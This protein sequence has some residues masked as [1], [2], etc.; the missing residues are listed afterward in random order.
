MRVST[1]AIRLAKFELNILADIL[2][3][4]YSS[5]GGSYAIKAALD[6]ISVWLI[7]VP[8]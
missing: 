4:P 6:G 3:E 2:T 7:L 1:A 5:V 8:M